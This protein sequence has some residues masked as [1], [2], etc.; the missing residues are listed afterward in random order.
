MPVEKTDNWWQTRHKNVLASDFSQ[1]KI[2]FLG[3]SITQNWEEE[4]FGYPVWQQY[5]GDNAVNLGFSADKTQHL[6]WRITNGEIDNISPEVTILLIGTNNAQDDSAAEIAKGVNAIIDVIENKLPETQLIVH[7]IFPRGKSTEPL[8]SVTDEASEIFSQRANTP[9]IT[10]VDI[11]EYF[12]DG[13]GDVPQDIMPDGLH[14]STQGYTIWANEI[15]NYI[16]P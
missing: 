9:N 2:L 8:R 11:N 4:E 6:L 1:A 5:Y 14:L 16:S 10:Y 7:R 3:D 13:Q 15:S 12:L